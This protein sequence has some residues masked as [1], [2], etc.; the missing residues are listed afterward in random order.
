MLCSQCRIGA[1]ETKPNSSASGPRKWPIELF[2]LPRL[3]TAVSASGQVRAWPHR[4]F[5]HLQSLR[6]LA[7]G[8]QCSCMSIW[9]SWS[10][11]TLAQAMNAGCNPGPHAIG[12]IGTLVHTCICFLT[13]GVADR[14]NGASNAATGPHGSPCSRRIEC[15]SSAAAHLHGPQPLL[16]HSAQ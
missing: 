8:Q 16:S 14:A 10:I 7:S 6:Q 1:A 15:S 3:Q 11:L 12:A 9:A 5:S 2:V 4:Q 13:S